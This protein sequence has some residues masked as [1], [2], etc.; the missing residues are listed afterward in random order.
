[1]P[2]SILVPLAASGVLAIRSIYP[3]TLGANVG[4]TITALLAAMAAS[5]P[6]A[7][8]IAFVHT[9]FNVVGIALI[10]PIPAIRYLPVKAAELLAEVA[11]NR[12]IWALVYVVGVFIVIPLVGIIAL[13]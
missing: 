10:W 7:L 5:K 11:T 12:R 13:S 8:T 9:L 1:L 3:V 4:T 6:E 2:T